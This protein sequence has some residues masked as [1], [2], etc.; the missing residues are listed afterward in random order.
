MH[1]ARQSG[2]RGVGTEPDTDRGVAGHVEL[3]G[4]ATR[5]LLAINRVVYSDA[6]FLRQLPPDWKP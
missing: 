4:E 1:L 2:M 6:L 5:D 3:V